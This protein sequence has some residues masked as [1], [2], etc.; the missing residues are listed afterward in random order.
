MGGPPNAGGVSEEIIGRW[1]AARGN[2]DEMVIATKVR[3]AMGGTSPTCLDRDGRFSMRQALEVVGR[4]R[5][6]AGE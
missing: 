5:E 1:L 6:G 3:A 4:L 2:R